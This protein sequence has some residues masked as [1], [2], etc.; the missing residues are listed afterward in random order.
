[1]SELNLV[2]AINLGLRQEMSRDERVVVL[3]EDVGVNGG[4]FRVT[5]GL[6]NDF[7]G[8]VFDT[9]LAEAGIIGVSVGLAVY[10]LRPVAEIQFEGFLFPAFNQLINHAARIRW[11]SRGKY[12]CPLVVRCPIGGG[13][14]A[15]EHH[16]DS[17]EAYL[18]HTPG[19]KVV[20]P[21][22]PH[23]AKGLIVSAIRDSDPV[24]FF[25][26]KRIYRAVKQEVPEEEYTVP[27]GKARVVREGSDV[28]IISYGAMVREC[29]Q[30]IDLLKDVS[31]ELIDL[32]TLNPLDVETIIR[33]V[34]KTGRVVVVHEAQRSCGVGAEIVALINERALLY[35]DAPVKRVTGYDVIVPLAKS[36]DYYIVNED[37]IVKGVME[38][39]KF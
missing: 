38:V 9:P 8:R 3:G 14:K 7:P 37:R 23:D 22:T 30:A 29:H 31:V 4:V 18:V 26:P 17:P 2:Q 39:L 12:S 10:G 34:K 20:I 13:I 16:G 1:M 6:I 19:L 15:L 33:S 32:R 11:R 25:E 27:I 5:N 28:T 24:I 36:E 35:L 21:S